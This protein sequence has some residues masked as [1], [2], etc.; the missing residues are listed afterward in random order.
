MRRPVRVPLAE[1]ARRCGRR[2]GVQRRA[3]L[4]PTK[5]QDVG[6]AG[7]ELGAQLAEQDGR[8]G[9]VEL[10]EHAAVDD[11]ER[12]HR[13]RV[14]RPVAD[15]RRQ[16]ELLDAREHERPRLAVALEQERVRPQRALVG[17]DHDRED[18]RVG[19][20]VPSLQPLPRLAERLE[21]G[22]GT[23]GANLRRHAISVQGTSVW[24][25]SRA[26]AANRCTVVRSSTRQSSSKP[27]WTPTS[28]VPSPE[29]AH[30]REQG[31]VPAQVGRA[32]RHVEVLGRQ[33]PA[34]QPAPPDASVPVGRALQ[35]PPQPHVLD[36]SDATDAEAGEDADERF[37]E[38]AELV[39]VAVRVDVRDGHAAVAQEGEL[40]LGLADDVLDRDPAQERAAAGLAGGQEATVVV[41]EAAELRGVGE[42]PLEAV[43][44]ERQMDAEAEVGPRAR[45]RDR[46]VRR[47][48]SRHDRRARQ[49]TLLEALDRRAHGLLRRAE[50]V[51]VEDDQHAIDERCCR[52]GRAAA[53]AGRRSGRRRHRASTRRGRAG[54][55]S[56]GTVA[57]SHA[58]ERI[59]R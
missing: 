1:G 8:V 4:E 51:G 23:R 46:R 12:A 43:G 26:A 52:P 5:P 44:D 40:R 37:A 58:S 53:G 14:H 50:V 54:A 20:D 49:R 47:R 59:R 13:R 18:V 42:R 10:A 32:R 34:H 36:V 41:D 6:A 48:H 38:G 24:P 29:L 9:V 45:V 39:H 33:E 56:R 15:L 16:L 30:G 55:G 2:G 22:P 27:G 25:S 57:A 17:R 11:G 21:L 19:R 3:D 31:A 28:S 35:R 7:G